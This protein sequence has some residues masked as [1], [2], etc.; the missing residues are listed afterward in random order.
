M[1]QPYPLLV[2]HGQAS[3]C[4]GLSTAGFVLAPS[5]VT[6]GPG[7]KALIVGNHLPTLRVGLEDKIEELVSVYIIHS[8]A[9][10]QVDMQVLEN[11]YSIFAHCMIHYS[12]GARAQF[13]C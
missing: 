6:P 12:L 11:E 9:Q 13:Y 4:T 10:F 8:K 5:V 1:L 7:P 2:Y 3:A